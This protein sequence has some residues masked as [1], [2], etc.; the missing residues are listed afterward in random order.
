MLAFLG[1][2][3]FLHFWDQFE[4]HLLK[5]RI[6]GQGGDCDF[7]WRFIVEW[8][9]HARGWSSDKVPSV[10]KLSLKYIN[11]IMNLL[12]LDWKVKSKDKGENLHC[13]L[14][15]A[16]DVRRISLDLSCHIQEK[17]SGAVWGVS[18]AR[19]FVV[20]CSLN[21]EELQVGGKHWT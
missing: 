15:S 6:L 13:G 9:I 4:S 19:T 7:V 2:V 14:K 11:R 5:I 16:A 21:L 8:E 12:D 10:L 1:R 20:L 18:K 3:F 17:V